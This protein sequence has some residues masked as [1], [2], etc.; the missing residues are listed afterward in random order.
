M[1]GL[2]CKV[3]K[4]ASK[5]DET[6]YYLLRAIAKHSTSFIGAKDVHGRY[7]Y[8]NDQYSKLF[9]IPEEQFLNRTDAEIFPA[10][11]A[12]KFR[13]ADLEVIETQ[14]YILV[15]EQAPVDGKIH[16]YLSAKF[17]IFDKANNLFATGIIAT[18][19][20]EQKAL[21]GKLKELAETDSLTGV[22]N[23]RKIFEIAE[24]EINKALRYQTPLSVIMLDV[25]EFKKVNDT[26]GHSWG[27]ATLKHI[28]SICCANIRKVDEFGR[29]GG[30]EFLAILP[31]TPAS[32]ALELANK[33]IECVRNSIRKDGRGEPLKTTISAGVAELGEGT[34]TVAA[35]INA[36]DRALYSAKKTGRNR[37]CFRRIEF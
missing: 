5:I 6:Q 7:L 20:S 26:L 16:H 37:A 31:H 28:V 35:L 17:P 36:A 25:D 30:D 27:D 14:E 22:A 12:L 32:S 24:K 3:K 15:E 23:R 34:G 33:L 29:I 19:I 8:V 1:T 4:L 11:V 9:D 10:E 18:D 2:A 13:Q 21:E